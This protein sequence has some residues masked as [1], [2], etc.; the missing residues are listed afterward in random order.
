MSRCGEAWQENMSEMPALEEQ[1]Y[2]EAV[3]TVADFIYEGD[4][5]ME[6]F[7]KNL[8]EELNGR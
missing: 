7:E 5:S 1:A 2:Y 8:K 6:Q 3:Q 4:V